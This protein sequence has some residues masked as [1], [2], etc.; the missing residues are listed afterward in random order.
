VS[1]RCVAFDIG[2]WVL[3]SLLRSGVLRSWYGEGVSKIYA[4]K[5][6]FVKFIIERYKDSSFFFAFHFFSFSAS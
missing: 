2:F 3:F 6:S 5:V 1:S 4:L